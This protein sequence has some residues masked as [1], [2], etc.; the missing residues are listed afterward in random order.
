P[1]HEP[2]LRG[3][4]LLSADP[5]TGHSLLVAPGAAAGGTGDTWQWDGTDW[6]EADATPAGFTPLRAHLAAD[7]IVAGDVVLAQEPA[8]TWVWDGAH[9]QVARTSL[10]PP[11]HSALVATLGSPILFGGVSAD[12]AYAVKFR[13]AATTWLQLDR[14]GPGGDMVLGRRDLSTPPPV[15][16]LSTPPPLPT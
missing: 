5:T 15:R 4:A 14:L 10:M 9:W 13:W 16:D 3:P 11:A 1:A 8:T 2:A 12:A 7:G 6:I